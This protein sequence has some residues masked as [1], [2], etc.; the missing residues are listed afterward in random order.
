MNALEKD[1]IRVHLTKVDGITEN[2]VVLPTLMSDL[3]LSEL[4]SGGL[5]VYQAEDV[6]KNANTEIISKYRLRAWVDAGFDITGVNTAY[7][8]KFRV[9]IN[10][11]VKPISTW[12][13]PGTLAYQIVGPNKRYVTSGQGVNVSYS[14][15]SGKPSYY[16]RGDVKNNCIS[17]ANMIWKI[18]RINE[19]RTIRIIL[20]EGINEDATYNFNTIDTGVSYD[21]R[22]KYMYYSE[23][24][25]DG[26]AMK[27]LNEWYNTNLLN[28]Q[29]QIVMSTYCEAAKAKYNVNYT[30]GNANVPYYLNYNPSFKCEPDANGYGLLTKN[31]GLITLDEAL[32]ATEDYERSNYLEYGKR[33]HTMS[34]AGVTDNGNY[35][36]F[37]YYIDG[38]GTG[39]LAYTV[40]SPLRLLPVISLSADTL[41]EDVPFVTCPAD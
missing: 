15:D 21:Q 34:P 25:V 3:K 22:Y 39:I 41:V 1:A 20:S 5:V 23:S 13:E 32:F 19:D 27:V 4:S 11:N 24:N 29:D 31:I 8:Y 38:G 12:P 30:V 17:F 9:N 26:G 14:T 16:Y 10:S 36:P 33:F 40:Y 6:H 37:V 7:Q 2:E 18:V 35:S 28:Y